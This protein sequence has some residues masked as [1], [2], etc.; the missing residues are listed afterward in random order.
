MLVLGSA[1]AALASNPRLPAP[2]NVAKNLRIAIDSSL[3]VL[4]FSIQQSLLLLPY[5]IPRD[6]LAH[7]PIAARL[8]SSVWRAPPASNSTSDVARRNLT[9]R[10][11]RSRCSAGFELTPRQTGTPAA[12]ARSMILSTAFLLVGCLC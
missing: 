9:P 11:I 2:V 6:N 3:F 7:P 5:N 1:R 10:A 8:A 12:L 4:P